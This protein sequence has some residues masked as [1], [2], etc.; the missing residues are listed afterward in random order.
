MTG[1]R[2]KPLAKLEVN[3]PACCPRRH[4][5]D[6]SVVDSG[7]PAESFLRSQDVQQETWRTS[8]SDQNN[9]I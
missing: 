4:S 9:V 6:P 1:T 8:L 2:Q 3:A 7:M 5:G